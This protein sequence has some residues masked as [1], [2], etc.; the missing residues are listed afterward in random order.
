MAGVPKSSR[1]TKQSLLLPCRE[2]LPLSPCT[3]S[4]KMVSSW[5]TTLTLDEFAFTLHKVT[6]RDA[7]LSGM[8]GNPCTYQP[9]VPVVLLLQFSMLYL[10]QCVVFLPFNIMRSEISQMSEACRDVSNE[11]ALQAITSEALSSAPAIIEDGARL[12]MT[13]SGIWGGHYEHAFLKKRAYKQR[14]GKLNTVICRLL[15]CH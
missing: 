10:V 7:I 13:A 4:T 2:P 3:S 9:L 5:L 14:F 1:M 15:C 11:S 12:D 6:F 8:A